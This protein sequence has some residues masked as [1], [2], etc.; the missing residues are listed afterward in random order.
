MFALALPLCYTFPIVTQFV[1]RL[2]LSSLERVAG[3]ATMTH[4]KDDLVNAL[5]VR[6]GA[7][8]SR[9]GGFWNGL[10]DTQSGKFAYVAIPENSPVHPGMEKP[11]SDVEQALSTFGTSLPP[12]LRSRHMHL[13]PDFRHLTYGDAG[14]RAKQL[15][16]HLSPGDVIVFYAGLRDVAGRR[17]LVYAIIGVFVVEAMMLATDIAES[18]RDINAHSRRILA[19]GAQDVIIRARPGISGRLERCLSIGE[20]RDRAYRVRRDVLEAWGGLSV[21]DGYLQRSARLPKFH[22]PM[23]FQRWLNS[24][25]P[26]LVQANN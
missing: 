23:R 4:E 5:L 24:K 11:Y 25:H 16:K 6:V 9:G 15:R 18:D 12:G 22:D 8:Q 7:D 26:I 17:E 21:K 13:D 14:E 3:M 2:A 20:W 10:V 19:E 1:F